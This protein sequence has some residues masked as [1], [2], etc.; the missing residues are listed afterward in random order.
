MTL[1]ALALLARFAGKAGQADRAGRLWGAI[2]TEESRGPVGIWENER[3]EIA[4]DVADPSPEF[5][6]GRSSGRSLSLEE[7]VEYALDED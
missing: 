4:S 3:D 1:Y 2:E 5:E 6:Q 7:A